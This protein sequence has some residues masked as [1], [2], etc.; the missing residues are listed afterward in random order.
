MQN[1]VSVQNSSELADLALCNGSN[2]KPEWPALFALTDAR[3]ACGL[4]APVYPSYAIEATEAQ[5]PRGRVQL[6]KLLAQKKFYRFGAGA[7]CPN[8][9]IADCGWLK[10]NPKNSEKFRFSGVR[11]GR[12]KHRTATL[13]H[14]CTNCFFCWMREPAGA[15]CPS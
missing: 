15:T 6:I 7:P 2:N 11:C 1:K 13:Q 12:S 4:C 8:A 5:S 14:A 10:P 3:V 9:R